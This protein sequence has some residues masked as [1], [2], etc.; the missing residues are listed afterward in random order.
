MQ[1]GSSIHTYLSF[2]YVF[3]GLFPKRHFCT[4][5]G[6]PAV[7]VCAALCSQ[8][9]GQLLDHS[10]WCCLTPLSWFLGCDRGTR[11]T[12]S[13]YKLLSRQSSLLQANL[14]VSQLQQTYAFAYSYRKHWNGGDI[15]LQRGPVPITLYAFKQSFTVLVFFF[16][17][18]L[19]SRNGV[20]EGCLILREQKTEGVFSGCKGTFPADKQGDNTS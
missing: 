4:Q 9:S 8:I 5:K 12:S 11:F 6:S 19:Q 20:R 16:G 14:F 10:Q 7:E 1:P 13:F 2:Q 15:V 18:K 17:L 3:R